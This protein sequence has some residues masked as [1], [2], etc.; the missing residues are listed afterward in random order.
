MVLSAMA[1]FFFFNDNIRMYRLISN[2]AAIV[3]NASTTLIQIENKYFYFKN[4][5]NKD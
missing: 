4:P 5:I 2:K 1:N 3:F